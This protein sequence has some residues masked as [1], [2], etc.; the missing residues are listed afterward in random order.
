[1][2]RFTNKLS[3]VYANNKKYFNKRTMQS[4]VLTTAMGILIAGAVVCAPVEQKVTADVDIMP[5]STAG[6]FSAVSAMEL[7]AGGSDLNYASADVSVVAAT[8]DQVKFEDDIYE[9]ISMKTCVEKRNTIGAPGPD[10]MSE[11]IAIN[12]SFLKD[13]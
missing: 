6:V 4:A 11:V 3:A 8:S 1:M 2:V 12:E 10:A 9:A 5:A 13:K 7:T